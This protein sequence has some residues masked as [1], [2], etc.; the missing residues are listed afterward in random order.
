M[1]KFLFSA[2]VSFVSFSA[3]SQTVINAKD[4]ASH[5]NEKVVIT[6]IVA[7]GKYL[8]GSDITLLDIGA[9]HPNELLTLLIKG[10]DRK[11]FTTAPETAFKGKKVTI[12]GMVIDYKGK[13]EIVITEP[14]QIKI[15]E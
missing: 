13:P 10:D 11:K 15:V 6:D 7:G 14:E 3:F 4:A 2:I 9:A 12:T 5:K 8:S 1:K